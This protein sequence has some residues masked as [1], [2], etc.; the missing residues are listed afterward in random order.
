MSALRPVGEVINIDGTERHLLFTLN[1]VEQIQDKY[2]LSINEIINTVFGL[3]PESRRKSFSILKYIVTA[4]INEDV[5]IHNDHNEDKWKPVTEKYIGRN[6]SLQNIGIISM[7][8]LKAYTNSLP[9][10]DE[11]EI[12]EE[13]PNQKSE[14]QK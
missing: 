4:L 10:P 13:I 7:A 9:E 6:I 8:V 3:D 14:Q 2:D 11:N 12:E 5:E 1:A